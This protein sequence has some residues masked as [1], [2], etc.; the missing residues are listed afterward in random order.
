LSGILDSTV[1]TPTTKFVIPSY[2]PEP[3]AAILAALRHIIN[4]FGSRN[5]RVDSLV[6][7]LQISSNLVLCISFSNAQ[8]SL[9]AL[10]LSALSFDSVVFALSGTD[11]TGDSFPM[12]PFLVL[13]GSYTQATSAPEPETAKSTASASSDTEHHSREPGAEHTVDLKHVI[14][15]SSPPVLTALIS[16]VQSIKDALP[17]ST[18]SPAVSLSSSSTPTSPLSDTSLLNSLQTITPELKT[19]PDMSIY[20]DAV[21]SF[22]RDVRSVQ[23]HEAALPGPSSLRVN[24]S[25]LAVALVKDHDDHSKL[26]VS[27]LQ[28]AI[29]AAATQFPRMVDHNGPCPPCSVPIS[30]NGPPLSMHL[31]AVSSAEMRLA[32]LERPTCWSLTAPHL[33][34]LEATPSSNAQASMIVSP[35]LLVGLA[36]EQDVPIHIEQS[37][38]RA[39][40]V[41]LG[42][43][44][45][46][47]QDSMLVQNLPTLRAWQDAL[48]SPDAVAASTPSPPPA[49][50]PDGDAKN[51]SVECA[52]TA[53]MYSDRPSAPALRLH[54]P[55]LSVNTMPGPSQGLACRLQSI[56]VAVL[57][58]HGPVPVL[59]ARQLRAY[60]F[61]DAP[62]SA[63]QLA[64]TEL[65]A[66]PLSMHQPSPSSALAD[67]AAQEQARAFYDS[68]SFFIPSARAPSSSSE[69]GEDDRWASLPHAV[70]MFPEIAT[71][72]SPRPAPATQAT[73]LHHAALTHSRSSV[74]LLCD[75]LSVSLALDQS[76]HLVAAVTMAQQ[77]AACLSHVGE[78]PP[79]RRRSNMSRRTPH[80]ASVPE[81]VDAF[82]TATA[83][84][85]RDTD[86]H[87]QSISDSLSE[88]GISLH[89]LRAAVHVH[90]CYTDDHS[91]AAT[92]TL[93][94]ASAVYIKDYARSGT[95]EVWVG[96]QAAELVDEWS[97]NGMPSAP[98]HRVLGLSPWA[99][100]DCASE[101]LLLVGASLIATAR[102]GAQ[103]PTPWPR[104]ACLQSLVAMHLS[105]L[106]HM[107]PVAP[108]LPGAESVWSLL[109]RISNILPSDNNGDASVTLDASDSHEAPSTIPLAFQC[110]VRNISVL[111]SAQDSQ[112]AVLAVLERLMAQRSA[113]ANA[114]VTITAEHVD[115]HLL[116]ESLAAQ[117][118]ISEHSLSAASRIQRQAA[119]VPAPA[120]EEDERSTPTPTTAAAEPCPETSS[121]PPICAL[122]APRDWSSLLQTRN[123]K[124]LLS[125]A[126]GLRCVID[127]LTHVSTVSDASLSLVLD[128]SSLAALTRISRHASTKASTAP[129]PTVSPCVT[130]VR[131]R[132][133]SAITGSLPSSTPTVTQYHS[134]VSS[135]VASAAVSSTRAPYP[136]RGAESVPPG[137]EFTTAQ[138]APSTLQAL[139][140]DESSSYSTMSKSGIERSQWLRNVHPRSWNTL[141]MFIPDFFTSV[142]FGSDAQSL[143]SPH[144]APEPSSKFHLTNCAIHVRVV[145]H[146]GDAG[147][148]PARHADREG[149]GVI[150]LQLDGLELLMCQYDTSR[151]TAWH[152]LFHAEIGRLQIMDH[153]QHCLL[154]SWNPPAS[155]GAPTASQAWAH[156]DQ[157]LV[158]NATLRQQPT[159]ALP[160]WAVVGFVHAHALELRYEHVLLASRLL[161]QLEDEP[162]F[163]A[164]AAD[165]VAEQ[166]PAASVP[167]HETA[168]DMDAP[169][170]E[171]LVHSVELAPVRLQVCYLG[172]TATPASK[173]AGGSPG[174]RLPSA[175]AAAQE[176]QPDA[177]SKR[178]ST[179]GATPRTRTFS[180]VLQMALSFVSVEP[181]EVTLPSVQFQPAA[182]A[183]AQE[184]VDHV[185]GVWTREQTQ[186]IV[187][188][189]T[190]IPAVAVVRNLLVGVGQLV[191]HPYS[192]V[193][194][195]R[196]LKQG[197][198]EA[199]QG[200]MGTT[201]T[202]LSSR[203]SRAVAAVRSSL[204]P[205]LSY[206]VPLVRRGD[207]E[208]ER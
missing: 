43:A 181:V 152:Q 27:L 17:R 10:V 150:F 124:T 87:S 30:A 167:S 5:V 130:P 4:Y 41:H 105:N 175:S 19:V 132:T 22:V 148:V 63:D 94:D 72:L 58:E 112:D 64:S 76:D 35:W 196:E 40:K 21:S 98:S 174:G 113:D 42:H 136:N 15:L 48:A 165:T 151:S 97:R 2:Q 104:Q 24:C 120:S 92:L 147:G 50:A 131:S 102:V 91:R 204:W 205:L 125:L 44:L 69:P 137:D 115:V 62:P 7:S 101:P 185:T 208:N 83:T 68:G 127:S 122:S 107:L 173:P 37:L 49:P 81:D 133:S 55:S 206:V 119:P 1:L 20:H 114:P 84:T 73:A 159:H 183:P 156:G 78:K 32:N 195:G 123:S 45:L 74:R 160:A 140:M 79:S 201:V 191:Y 157:S 31:L 202:D 96:I 169:A 18:D 9:K 75:S 144:D 61:M 99:S 6:I 110:R 111:L 88:L 57:A 33:V 54:V 8:F 177:G 38:Q 93:Q 121:P 13:S 154:T 193:R 29:S 116:S 170:M 36:H 128:V 85:D 200:F 39:I 171:T 56:S 161:E 179:D 146:A 103:S 118:L 109:G 28:N 162:V 180:S 198:R 53:I 163:S 65:A 203:G 25:L 71:R 138:S 108:L 143:R 166:A 155:H 190:G 52:L 176:A 12:T 3:D 89:L 60:V 90:D 188:V 34:F 67:A 207:A 153:L 186:N 129:S 197:I 178:A 106:L 86:A 182:P 145:V 139:V 26:T 46:C 70:T 66:T 82:V 95:D 199:W 80:L 194:E 16:A 192:A 158:L 117:Q 189:V 142:R 51:L 149:T 126:P 47:L 135:L 59:A 141:P 14:A 77:F 172:S 23:L 134:T 168:R 100:G 187:Q 11:S 164:P 184:A